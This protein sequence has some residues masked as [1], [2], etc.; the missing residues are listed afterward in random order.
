[1]LWL[2]KGS[3][4]TIWSDSKLSAFGRS[5]LVQR[6]DSGSA[7]WSGRSV[8]TSQILPELQATW[9]QRAANRMAHASLE[10]RKLRAAVMTSL[11]V[12]LRQI[13]LPDSMR[14][15]SWGPTKRLPSLSG[16]RMYSIRHP[17][18]P[19]LYLTAKSLAPYR[20]RFD[21]VELLIMYFIDDEACM[22]SNTP[23]VL[24]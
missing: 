9:Q 3:M 4:P 5:T 20:A 11:H 19:S 1:M 12:L 10:S 17:H 21:Q 14:R 6:Y 8:S 15:P 16:G 18:V 7:W 24:P 2:D 13:Q 23:M 22:S